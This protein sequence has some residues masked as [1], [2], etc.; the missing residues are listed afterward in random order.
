M[1]LDLWLKNKYPEYS[2]VY[3]QKKILAGQIF[4]NWKKIVR[5]HDEI[6]DD[7]L[8]EIQ[9][10]QP[11]RQRERKKSEEK[12][13]FEVLFEDAYFFIIDKPAGIAVHP[14][15][16]ARTIIE[17]LEGHFDFIK[18]VHR[19]DRDTSGILVFAKSEKAHAALSRLWK[20]HKVEKEYTTL[21]KGKFD[22][23]QGVINAPI[24]RSLKDRQKM[25]VSSRRGAR[26]SRTEFEVINVVSGDSLVL[27]FPKTGRTHQIRVHFASI[28]HPVIGDSLYGDKKLNE[29]FAKMG[30]SR[31]FLHA[32]A[33][34]FRHPFKK[35]L[36][37]FT[38]KLSAD[39]QGCLKNL[40]KSD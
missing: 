25:A 14:P 13:P 17:E 11:V 33:L 36:V 8:V 1:R 31:Q 30:L 28:G 20:E 19:L 16:P 38:S 32:S 10:A 34:S 24:A 18:P 12:L 23:P 3:W 15:F 6:R 4:V 27:V 35:K 2:R 7:A 40:K 39:L 29:K 26:P 22:S 21:V 9:A 37:Q 5:P